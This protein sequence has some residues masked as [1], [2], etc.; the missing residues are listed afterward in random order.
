MYH[1]AIS[2]HII[3]LI[4]GIFER[5]L[6]FVAEVNATCIKLQLGCCSNRTGDFTPSYFTHCYRDLRFLVVGMT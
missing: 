2:Y 3:P 4:S 6:I 5:E 1:Y